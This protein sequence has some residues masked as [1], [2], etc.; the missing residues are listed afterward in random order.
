[1]GVRG[2][3]EPLVRGRRNSPAHTCLS[4][5]NQDVVLHRRLHVPTLRYGTNNS[6]LLP[7]V[8]HQQHGA[9]ESTRI[10]SELRGSVVFYMKNYDKSM[11]LRSSPRVSLRPGRLHKHRH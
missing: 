8:F 2:D 9:H 11:V 4:H 6:T 10:E 7:C 3:V 1:M 5:M